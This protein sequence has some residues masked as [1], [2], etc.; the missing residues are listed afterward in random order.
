[1]KNRTFVIFSLLVLVAV[2]FCLFA[3]LYRFEAD[4][5]LKKY[6]AKI[7]V[8]GNIFSEDDC[9]G[10]DFCEGIYG[11][12]CPT[13][14]D[15]EFKRCQQVSNKFLA[16]IKK[17]KEICQGSGGEWYRNKLG[18]FCLCQKNG[19]NKVWNKERGCVSE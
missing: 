19:I 17:E 1:M 15:L 10:K 14:A 12:V 6:I 3:Y 13:C 16:Q 8:C 11:P 7:T 9:Y 2:I 18:N 4:K 5:L